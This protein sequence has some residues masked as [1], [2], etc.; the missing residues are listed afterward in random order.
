MNKYNRRIICD[1]DDTISFTTDRNWEQATP[2]VPLIDKL[3]KLYDN[4]W[5]I[6]YYTARGC[7]S[8]NGDRL[9]AEKHYRPIIIKWFK[10]NNVKYTLLSFNKP[11]GTYYI[12]DKSQTP[13]DFL[14]LK[15]EKIKGGL[16]GAEIERRGDLV[17]K[18]H[19]NSL[20]CAVWYKEASNIIKTVK[21]HSLIGDTLCLEYIEKTDEPKIH[22]I[23]HI[24]QKFKSIPAD[25]DI[26][27]YIDR[28]Q[29]HLNIYNPYYKEKVINTLKTYSTV[30]NE[31]KSFSHGDMSLDNMINRNGILYLIDP[32]KPKGLYSSWM[33]D[34]AKILH[35]SK[36]FNKPKIYDY[37]IKKYTELSF[38]LLLLELTHWI[39]MRSYYIKANG[40]AKFVD[41]NINE[42]LE[43]LF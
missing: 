11:L 41:K 10:N 16:S 36:R 3:N 21:V 26:N 37:F 19:P 14:N 9:A 27:T 22:Q 15:I 8:F 31:N 17:Y 5:E 32:I 6:C 43:E 42:L 39:R 1:I 18:R 24:I 33:L 25:E 13:D 23:D 4:G 40:N 35:S 12:D 34:V 7:L 2:N 30:Y 28:I 38:E 29:D 20:E